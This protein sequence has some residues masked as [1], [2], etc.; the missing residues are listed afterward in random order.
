MVYQ[1]NEI[2]NKYTN[3]NIVFIMKFATQKTTEDNV[4]DV[5]T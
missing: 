2:V 4:S 3:V 5:F 1:D